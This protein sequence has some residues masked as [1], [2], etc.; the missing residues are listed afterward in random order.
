[1][2]LLQ[3]AVGVAAAFLP[4]GAVIVS[5]KGQATDSKQVFNA[6][7]DTYKLSESSDPL[8]SVPAMFKKIPMVVL[9]NAYS[10]SASEIVAGALQDYKRAT[11]IGKTS[12]GKGSVQTVRPL[13]NDSALKITTAYYYTPNGRSIQGFGIKPDIPVD[14]NKDGDPDDVLITREVDSEKHLRNKQSSEDAL[15]KDREKRRLEE[16]QR[17]EEKNATKTPADRDKDKAKKPP[18]LGSSDDFMLQQAVA[19]LNG[20]AVIRSSSKLE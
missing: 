3:G 8:A 14:Q 15:I 10:A 18:E 16:M 17:I 13:S 11:I 12:F 1:G 2:G 4:A 7:P 19:F 20:K 9:V 5:T 6:N